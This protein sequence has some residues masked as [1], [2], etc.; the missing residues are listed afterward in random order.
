MRRAFAVL[1]AMLL[2][3]GPAAAVEL[4]DAVLA[5]HNTERA[6]IGTAPLTWSDD[7]A[8]QATGWARHLAELGRLEHSAAADRPGEGENLWMGTAGGY[9]PR[10]MVAGWTNEKA[11]FRPGTFPDVARDGHW[12]AVGHYAQMIWGSTTEIGCALASSPQWDVLV[13]RYAP[14]GNLIGAAPF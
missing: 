4:R 14:A 12:Q 3:S 6:A 13:C 9:T 7:L 2:S 10:E 5:A 8:A 11:D 1:L